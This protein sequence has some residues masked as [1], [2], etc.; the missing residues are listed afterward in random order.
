MRDVVDTIENTL[1]PMKIALVTVRGIAISR[2]DLDNYVAADHLKDR[3]S[4]TCLLEPIWTAPL[5]C[6]LL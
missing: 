2:N 5:C 3:E 4:F 1:G 6:A